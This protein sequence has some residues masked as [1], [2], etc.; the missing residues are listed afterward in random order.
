MTR[1]IQFAPNERLFA[2]KLNQALDE[3]ANQSIDVTGISVR[4]FM[5]P[6]D[7]S[8]IGP[9]L[10]RIRDEGYLSTDRQNTI[11]IPS[12]DW[13]VQSLDPTGTGFALRLSGFGNFA[14][15]GAG[16][17]TTY[18]RAANGTDMAFMSLLNI[19]NAEFS[20]FTFDNNRQNQVIPNPT[21]PNKHSI[22]GASLYGVNFKRITILNANGSAFGFQAGEFQD[23]TIE[24]IRI[25]GSGLDGF[26]F[27]NPVGTNR[28]IRINRF[29]ISDFGRG[30]PMIAKAGIDI[31]GPARVTNGYVTLS[32]A[33]GNATNHSFYRAR[34]DDSGSL[35]YDNANI[36]PVEG[37]VVTGVSSGATAEVNAISGSSTLATGA[38]GLREVVGAFT[39]GEAITFSGGK[40]AT[41]RSYTS[42]INNGGGGAVF[43]N[44][45]AQGP[46]DGVSGIGFAMLDADVT[47]IAPRAVD[48]RTGV[49]INLGG[50]GSDGG[51]R[52]NLISPLVQRVEVGLDVRAQNT[53]VFGGAI[54]DAT[55]A[56]ISLIDGDDPVVHGVHFIDC[57]RGIQRNGFS[58]GLR[59]IDNVFTNTP[60]ALTNLAMGDQ[61]ATFPH[62]AERV[63][64][65]FSIL[66]TS[67]YSSTATLVGGAG[68]AANSSIYFF[69]LPLFSRVS[70][71]RFGIVSGAAVVGVSAKMALYRDLGETPGNAVDTSFENLVIEAP[72]SLSLNT[73][74]NAQAR[75]TLA[76]AVTLEPG[77]YWLALKANGAGRPYTVPATGPLGEWARFVGITDAGPLFGGSGATIR[78]ASTSLVDYDAPFPAACPLV[79]F[80]TTGTGSP[81]MFAQAG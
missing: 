32:T 14:L 62:V 30:D 71:I 15:R 39:N 4:G 19:S 38:L 76:S 79:T 21:R 11:T 56:A 35:T 18:I 29:F 63:S 27:K 50:P 26:D 74:A 25:E 49:T 23:I 59:Q 8:D 43:E 77:L 75:V 3:V 60:L 48:L 46:T 70:L 72:G 58:N 5:R 16:Q 52:A 20:D 6:E 31:R 44:C 73:V 1:S 53:R 45:I 57:A 51:V 24:D 64:T 2:G 67:N 78:V 33:V 7:G 80:G 10:R 54:T 34:P 40:T 65:V 17:D 42:P 41:C 55:E 81:F 61:R 66:P 28:N 9:A 68:G 47:L 22:R 13:V 69:P 12:G 36:L 37:D